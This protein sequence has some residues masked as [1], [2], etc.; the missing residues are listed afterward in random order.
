VGIVI[1]KNSSVIN[2]HQVEVLVRYGIKKEND[3]ME[4]FVSAVFI[5][6]ADYVRLASKIQSRQNSF[7][8]CTVARTDQESS[9]FKAE[10]WPIKQ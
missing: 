8:G 2:I 7:Q 10:L 5:P 9:P 6:L 3:G 4:T 1:E